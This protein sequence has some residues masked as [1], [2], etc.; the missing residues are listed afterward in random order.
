MTKARTHAGLKLLNDKVLDPTQDEDAFKHQVYANILARIFH[1]ESGN[2]PGISVA[3]FGKWGQG[4]SSVVEM[5]SKCLSKDTV[6]VIVFNAWQARGDSVRRQMFLKVLSTIDETEAQKMKQ[7]AGLEIARELIQTEKDKQTRKEHAKRNLWKS[8]IED[9]V[10]SW[11][12]LLLLSLLIFPVCQLSSA[13][14]GKEINWNNTV[15]QTVLFPVLFFLFKYIRETVVS[16]YTGL[17][18][19]S[20]PISESQ[21]LR[22]PEQFQELFVKHVAIFNKEQDKEL[23]IVVD[24][25]DRCEPET[26]VE[27]LASI[28]Q[29]SGSQKYMPKEGDKYHG[30]T[31]DMRCRFLV[32]CDE[33]QVALAL[34]TDGYFAGT[35]GAAYHDYQS[36]ELL[37]KFFDVVVRMDRFIPEDMVSYSRKVLEAFD[38]VNARDAEL[39]QELIGAVAPR[40][41]RQVKK[42]INT[43]LIFKEKVVAMKRA[44]VFRSEDT[45]ACFDK[46]LLLAIA[47]QETVPNLFEKFVESPDRIKELSQKSSETEADAGVKKGVRIIN[48]LKPVSANTFRMLTRKGL[49][50]TLLNVSNGPTIYDAV[51]SGEAVVFATE[52]KKTDNLAAVISW[53]KE[54]R[55]SL[56]SIAQFRHALS[57]LMKV[58]SPSDQM[59]DTINDFISSPHLQEALAGFDNLIGLASLSKRLEES[60][61]KIHDAVIANF[62]EIEGDALLTSDEL[63]AIFIFGEDLYDS[64]RELFV[65]KMSPLFKTDDLEVSQQRLTALQTEIQEVPLDNYKGFAPSLALTLA[66]GSSWGFYSTSE[67]EKNQG[68]HSGLIVRLV[69]DDPGMLDELIG[70]FF[71][72]E[73]P[74]GVPINLQGKSAKGEYEALLT[75]QE[76]GDRLS[77]EAVQDLNKKLTPWINGQPESPHTCFRAVCN[78]IR[79]GL[80]Q[81]SDEQL[82]EFAVLLTDRT[83]PSGD[84][85]WLCEY[86]EGATKTT[87]EQKRKYRIFCKAI[88]NQV[89]K[90]KLTTNEIPE[91]IKRLLNSMAEDRWDV[92]EEADTVFADAISNKITGMDAWEVWKESLWPLSK[93]RSKETTNAVH[94][95]IKANVIPSIL[96]PFAVEEICKKKLSYALQVTLKKYFKLPNS[97]AN[98]PFVKI[99]SD[100]SIKGSAQILQFVI[101]DLEQ[102]NA[103]INEAQIEF[104]V[105]HHRAVK[106]GSVNQL[107]KYIRVKYLQ[108]AEPG[109]FST[110]LS[111]VYTIGNPPSAVTDEIRKYATE[112]ADSL[113]DGEKIIITELLGEDIFPEDESVEGDAEKTDEA[114]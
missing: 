73:G 8:I 35:N 84:P 93:N 54:Y 14:L 26:V 98:D 28:R 75:L 49:P 5:L 16:K 23:L 44:K 94:E 29:L 91:P 15:T 52:V 27:A 30:K 59:L 96:I 38:E 106:K 68:L 53:L 60:K 18:G 62:C 47:L 13:I 55:K 107:M 110:G 11:T 57:C 2:E 19:I 66:E 34:E 24:D 33:Q 114:E 48:A 45:L 67:P 78:G 108:S 63:K 37:R 4:K 79:K 97:L 72:P 105:D 112:Q 58:E 32:P 25:L 42:L 102:G 87:D 69:G 7:F 50:E 43:Y 81:L 64:A 109:M 101:D 70:I 10:L 99:F 85:E 92:A 3:L 17:L 36:D 1:P 41:P 83:M 6:E 61:R 82:E 20:E 86:V 111:Y 31:L 95:R 39:I 9:K 89:S 40:D 46:T 80:F 77:E 71:R 90:T 51:L 88:F 56:N 76:L 74:L 113:T 65:N 12:F 22:Y 21:R 103:S 104:L 100:S